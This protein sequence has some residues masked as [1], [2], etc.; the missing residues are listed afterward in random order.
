VVGKLFFFNFKRS[1]VHVEPCLVDFGPDISPAT[2]TNAH[3]SKLV[4]VL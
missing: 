1:N 2:L 3:V 4:K